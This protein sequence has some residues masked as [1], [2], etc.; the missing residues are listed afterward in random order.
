[1]GSSL[2]MRILE[3][4]GRLVGM[5]FLAG[6]CGIYEDHVVRIVGEGVYQVQVDA[7]LLI[8]LFQGP[9]DFIHSL[10]IIHQNLV[11][12][13]QSL[14]FQLELICQILNRISQKS[15]VFP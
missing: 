11:F 8:A 5:Y 15:C 13:F 10:D 6:L 2:G 7:K 14:V 4:A 12:Q 9:A 3:P 1:M